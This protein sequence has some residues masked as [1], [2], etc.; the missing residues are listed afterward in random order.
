MLLVFLLCLTSLSRATDLFSI[1]LDQLTSIASSGETEILERILADDGALV[2]TGLPADYVLAVQG[3]KRKAPDCLESQSLPVFGLTDGSHRRTF[4][5]DSDSE[6]EYPDC[7]AE[8]ARIIHQQF[9]HLDTAMSAIILDIIGDFR[10]AEWSTDQANR[11][12]ILSKIYKEH[13]H[14]YTKTEQ[15][16]KDF[17]VP[18]HTDN[19]LLLFLTPDQSQPLA[20]R[21]K[22][23]QT[24][25]LRQVEEDSVIV[26]LGSAISGWLLKGTRS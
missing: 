19:G 5:L 25:E 8:E 2:V 15:K 1:S 24:V 13:I 23:G 7:V 9:D 21:N 12:S 14:V 17:A 3:L 4:A 18:F 10:K 26:I 16:V 20:V 11:G 6:T 22:L